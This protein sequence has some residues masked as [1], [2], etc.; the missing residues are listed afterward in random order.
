[1]AISPLYHENVTVCHNLLMTTTLYKGYGLAQ[2]LIVVT[3]MRRY[4][5]GYPVVRSCFRR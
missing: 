2:L 1:M 3:R 4:A 5:G